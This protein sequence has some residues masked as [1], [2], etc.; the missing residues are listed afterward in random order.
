[1]NNLHDLEQTPDTTDGLAHD[2]DYGDRVR[3]RGCVVVLLGGMLAKV[4][5]G[6]FIYN[7]FFA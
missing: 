4:L 7:T 5:F 3:A 2:D 1:M 6:W